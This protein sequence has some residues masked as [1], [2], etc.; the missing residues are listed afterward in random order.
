MRF[1]ERVCWTCNLALALG[2]ALGIGGVLPGTLRG[3][4]PANTLSAEERQAG[5]Q[6][7]F[8]G[9][10][11]RGW[12]AIDGAALPQRHVQE[13]SLNPHPC[14]YM[15]VYEQ[16]VQDFVLQL[17]FKISKNCN[18]GIFLRTFPLQAR[19]G[20]DVGYNGIEIAIDDTDRAD[21]YDTGAVYDLA[22]P[23]RNAMLPV[24]QWNRA[25]IDSVGSRIA[26]AINGQPVTQVDLAQFTEPN[27]RPD[28]SAH[29]FDIAYRDH[30]R[31]GYIGLQDHGS[32]C[33]YRNI[34]LKLLEKPDSAP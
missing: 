14:N 31:R 3:E 26:V 20:K 6:L 2:M 24:G 9:R 8:D 27:K 23:E 34:K 32:D 21:Y 30:P 19:P 25:R 7:L 29:K 10:S 17:E 33:W 5:W 22:K 15:L 16:P 13:G 28:G 18:S 11:T 1:L 4:T 12:M